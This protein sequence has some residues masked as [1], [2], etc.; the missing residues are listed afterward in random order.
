M[1][2]SLKSI[3]FE[4]LNVGKSTYLDKLLL[5]GVL[6]HK[7]MSSDVGLWTSLSIKRIRNVSM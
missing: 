6:R 5:L 2:N 4:T 3:N 1:Q 7:M